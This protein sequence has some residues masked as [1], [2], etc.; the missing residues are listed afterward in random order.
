MARQSRASREL[1]TVVTPGNVEVVRRLR[2][3]LE[4]TEEQ[5][6]EFQR[7]VSQQ[8][9]DWFSPGN[10][11][12]LCQYCRHVIMARRIADLIETEMADPTANPTRLNALIM[13]QRQESS[14]ICR[15]MTQLRLTPQA[16]APSRTSAAKV[17]ETINPF[18][19]KPA[20]D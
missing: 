17:Y 11:A 6:A 4:L 20:E 19:K 10:L 16:V 8:P 18:Y 12:L 1:L 14:I 5:T 15:L 9:A 2:P 3:P 7:V 13:A